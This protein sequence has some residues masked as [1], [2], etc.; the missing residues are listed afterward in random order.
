MNQIR[1]VRAE[2]LDTVWALVRRTVAQMIAWGSDQWGDDYPYLEAFAEDIAHKELWCVTDKDDTI[3]G[4]AAI[5]CRHEPDYEPLP[6]RRSEPAVSMHRVA[7]DP[8]AMGKGVAGMLFAQF[9][10]EGR[11][12]GV[13]SLRIDT[14]CMNERMQHLITKHGFT[15]L[16]EFY[17]PNRDNPYYCYD[18]LLKEDGV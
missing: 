7:V 15:K 4:V 5:V 13:D 12:R 9:E 18:K 11:R 6:F 16:A 1:L 2:E 10:K 17:F 3:L 8:C 14:Y